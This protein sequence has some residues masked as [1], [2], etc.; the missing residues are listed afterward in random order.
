[1]KQAK[2]VL[3][4][5]RIQKDGT[6]HQEENDNTKEVV[7]DSNNNIITESIVLPKIEGAIVMAEGA[8]NIEI[9]N[10]II[11]A[12]CAVTGLAS[13]KVQVFELEG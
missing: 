8:E 13:H 3:I 1:M 4:K 9:K 7:L 11:Q 12:V 5:K 6:R 2:I 10:N